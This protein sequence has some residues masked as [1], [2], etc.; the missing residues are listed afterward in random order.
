EIYDRILFHGEHLRAIQAIYDYTDTGM[1]AR[2]I[3]APKPA[4]WM[5]DAIY[6][7][8][9]ADPMV[10]DGAFQ[11][12][13]VWCFEQTGNVCL[14]SYARAYRQY[15]SVFPENGVRAVMTVTDRHHRKMTADFIFLDEDQEVVA[16]LSGYE[17]TIDANLMHAFR[18]N[19][20][21]PAAE[22]NAA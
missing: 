12:A 8:W 10:L 22:E 21:V 13:I 19:R 16:T 18:N 11:M 5:A 4:A 14:P 2:L 7:H 15:R 3:S 20:L 1:T 17:A 6:D 9:T